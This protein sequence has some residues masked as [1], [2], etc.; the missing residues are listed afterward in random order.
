MPTLR[1]LFQP[2]PVLQ[3]LAIL[4]QANPVQDQW[5]TMLDTVYNVRIVT[6]NIQIATTG[7][8]LEVRFTVD[9]IV[10]WGTLAATANSDYLVAV[11]YSG[12]TTGGLLEPSQAAPWQRT[13]FI[14]ECRSFKAELRKTTANGVGNLKGHIRYQQFT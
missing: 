12:E 13:S 10:L 2:P 11:G 9:G 6:T 5:Y 3:S 8:T 7:E 4:N 1:R 14:I